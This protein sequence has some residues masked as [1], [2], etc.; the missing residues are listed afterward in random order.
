MLPA[1]YALCHGGALMLATTR[2]F[3]IQSQIQQKKASRQR[4]LASFSYVL[5]NGLPLGV[6]KID[7]SLPLMVLYRATAV[8]WAFFAMLT[9]TCMKAAAR[10]SASSVEKR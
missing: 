1:R 9:E 5:L 6:G 8:S 7:S 3:P 10:V 2:E 4:L